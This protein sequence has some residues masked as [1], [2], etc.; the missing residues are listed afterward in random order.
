MISYFIFIPPSWLWN[1]LAQLY[2]NLRCGMI[3]TNIDFQI[4]S[5]SLQ[6]FAYLDNIFKLN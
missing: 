4:I 1:L 3:L 2:L 6:D 5:L